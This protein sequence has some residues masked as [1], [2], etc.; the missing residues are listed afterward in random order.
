MSTLLKPLKLSENLH[1]SDF[2][3]MRATHIRKQKEFF[4]RQMASEF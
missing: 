1:V 2:E 4:L 3:S